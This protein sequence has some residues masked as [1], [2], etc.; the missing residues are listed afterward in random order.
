MDKSGSIFILYT[1]A[2]AVIGFLLYN[3]FNKP[4]KIQIYNELP[5]PQRF[6]THW[7]GYGWRP[8]WRRY[9]GVPGLTPAEPIAPPKMPVAPKPIIISKV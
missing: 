8:W 6:N 5:P 2:I 9:G 4:Q 7:W 1:V 3:V